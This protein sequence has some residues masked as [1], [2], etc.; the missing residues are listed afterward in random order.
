VVRVSVSLP[1]RLEPELRAI[2]A[3]GNAIVRLLQRAGDALAAQLDAEQ[4]RWFLW[5]PVFFGCGIGIYFA[6]PYEPSGG[7]AAGFLAIGLAARILGRNELFT[8][9]LTSAALCITAGFATAKLRTAIMDAPVL[10]RHGAYDVEGFVES[11]ERQTPKRSKAVIRLTSLKLDNAEVAKRPFRVRASLRGDLTFRPGS[12][13]KMRAILGPPPDPAMPGGFDFAR[14][15]YYQGIGGSG[16]SLSKPEMVAGK[17]LPFDL[18]LRAPLAALR[19]QIGSR[20]TSILPGQTG[21]VAAALT[22]G[23][24]AG[25]DEKAMDDLRGS[26]LAHVI[27]ISGLHMSLVAG[28][29]FWFLR[30]VLA[31]FPSIALRYPVRTIAGG[32]AL[33]C[34]TVYLALSGA[35]IAAVRSYL[36]IAV[37]F[38][39]ILLNRPALSLRNIALAGFLILI[40]LPDSL[41]DVSFQMSFAATAA[42]IAGYERFGRYLHFEVK[43]V[44]ERL[45]WQPVY[46]LGGVL[47]TTATA[48]LAVEPFSAYHFHNLTSYA[49]LGN[50]LGGPPIDF[51]VMPAMVAALIAMPFG[52]EEWPL[53]L[54]GFGIDAMMAIAKYVASL[55]GALVPVPAFPFAALL[56]M[57][58]GGIWLLIWRRRWRLLGLAVIGAGVA[59]TSV[60][61]TPDILV[62]GQAKIV[63]VR[64]SDGQLQAPKSRKASYSLGQWLKASGDNRKPKEAATGRGFQCDAY[65]CLALVKGQLLSFISKPDAIAEDCQ[66]AVIL[67]APMDIRQPCPAPR[68]ILDRGA[69][70]E[71]GATAIY[72]SDAGILMS[73]ASESRGIRPWSPARHRR[74]FIPPVTEGSGQSERN[75]EESAE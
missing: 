5:V 31:L 37:V 23:Q 67:A 13:I 50:L 56:V 65:S 36:M 68:F 46:L 55:P 27:S 15:S 47:L 28:T 3:R 7:L 14:M 63:A 49:A 29:V 39:A 58:S 72:V 33:F 12:Y 57:I 74:E 60:Q 59:L 26:G 70:W 18:K 62:D 42:L 44:R 21:E 64:G 24:T 69:L 30:W 48:G 73:G 51:L 41:I 32:A 54:M 38:L 75:G 35:S 16:Y 45:L 8:F 9:L 71:K 10:E 17:E 34:V 4:G 52:L 22:V 1:A 53:R 11:F 2:E 20:I 43:S 40:V 61:D 25:L 6:L 19:A 66:R